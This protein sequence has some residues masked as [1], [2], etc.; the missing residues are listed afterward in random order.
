MQSPPQQTPTTIYKEMMTIEQEIL[1]LLEKHTIEE[2]TEDGF[3]S[4]LFTVPKRMGD[5]CPCLN[6]HPLNQLIPH[7]HFKME[8]VKVVCNLINKGDYMTSIDLQDAFLH[9]LIHSSLHKYL[10][11]HWKGKQYQ[12]R[13]LPFGLSLAPFVFTK[14]LKPVLHWAHR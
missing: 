10:Q 2:A 6:L 5:L 3:T 9:V 11:F 12:F 8:M 13:V 14:I 4:R 7:Q 1:N